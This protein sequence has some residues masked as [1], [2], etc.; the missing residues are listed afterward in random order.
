MV[1]SVVQTQH[2]ALQ[3]LPPVDGRSLAGFVGLK[4]GGATCYMNSVIQQLY[5]M[6][7][8]AESILSID[9]ENLNED[10]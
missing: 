1:L 2:C 3:Y 10:R 4:N 8:I 9:D 5:M 6:P 7:G